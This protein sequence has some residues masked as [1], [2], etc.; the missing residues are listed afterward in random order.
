MTKTSWLPKFLRWVFTAFTGLMLV[1]GIV[2]L[3]FM[4]NPSF[5]TGHGTVQISPVTLAPEPGAMTLKSDTGETVTIEKF[6]ASISVKPDAD[7]GL[8]K[9]VT[10][11]ALPMALIYIVFFAFLFEMLRRLFRNVSRAESFTDQNVRLVRLIGYS[12][13]VFSIAAA[14][15]EGWVERSFVDYLDTHTA[16]SSLKLHVVQSQNFQ[17]NTAE[18]SFQWPWFFTGLLVLALSEVFR[19]GLVLKRENDL[20]V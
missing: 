19:Q 17:I 15:A 20:T 12:I 18:T 2:L 9:L 7:G 11:R 8:A 16:V 5:F 4:F 14:V 6:D 10:Q 13:L 1:L 3:F